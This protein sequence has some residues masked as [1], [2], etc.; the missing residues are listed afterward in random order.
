MKPEDKI[1]LYLDNQMNEEERASFQKEL[2]GS[3][4]LKAELENYNKLF[5]E[6][7]SVKNVT[8][9]KEYFAEMIPKFHGRLEL[10]RRMRFIPRLALGMTTVAVAFVILFFT[11]NKTANKK[12]VVQNNIGVKTSNNEGSTDLNI[13][14]DQYNLGALTPAEIAYSNTV[15]DSL[16]YKEL[17]LSPQS[18][19]D[20]T[21]DNSREF[22]NIVQGINQKEADEIYNQL[23]HKKIF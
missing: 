7:D 12:E 1:I 20:Y 14:S 23:L 8:V 22:N 15:L 6:I 13:L 10:K 5:G 19:S 21:L 16:L 18:L 9:D 2:E 3:P 11:L 17:N 4:K